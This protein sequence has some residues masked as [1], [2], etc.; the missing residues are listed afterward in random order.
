MRSVGTDA[1]KG[2]GREMK[3]TEKVGAEKPVRWKLRASALGVLALGVMAAT[4]CG[5]GSSQSGQE[6]FL[7]GIVSISASESNNARFISG[8]K[9]VAKEKGWKV[10]VVDA[11]G[12]AEK[13]NT[14]MRNFATKDAGAIIDMVFPVTSIG[15]GLAATRQAGIPV[16]TWGGGIDDGVV[17]T[18]GAGGPLAEPIVEDMVEEMGGEGSVLALTYRSGLVCREREEVFDKVMADNPNIEVTKNE[19]GIPGFFQDGAQYS[20]AW[21]S[22]NPPDSGN[23][24]IWGC[25][26]DPALGAISGLKQRGRDDVQV[27]GQ[28]GNQEAINAVETGSMTATNYQNSTEEGRR[29][30]QTIDEAIKAGDG[31]KPKNVTVPGT[32]VNSDNIDQFL[33]E[34]PKAGG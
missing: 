7:L 29:L 18:T 22:G 33:K 24:A 2:K 23:L 19:V 28:N 11:D 5:A 27:Y 1:R 26:D 3:N 25:W 8:A 17:A 16:A 10:E 20:T 32:V 14:A 6:D 34:N 13:A 12:S 31:W 9:E 21:L 4:A 30:V 15:A